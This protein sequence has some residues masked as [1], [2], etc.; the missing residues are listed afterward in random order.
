MRRGT[1]RRKFCPKRRKNVPKDR[2]KMIKIG[3]VLFGGLVCPLVCCSEGDLFLDLYPL[4]FGV[5]VLKQENKVLF[6]GYGANAYHTHS[7]VST[8]QY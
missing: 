2:K 5:Y 4:K 8:Y 7:R 3:I 6:R 1:K